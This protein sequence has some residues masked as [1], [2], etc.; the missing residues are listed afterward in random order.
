MIA[1]KSKIRQNALTSADPHYV[2]VG[3]KYKEEPKIL[4]TTEDPP[5]TPPFPVPD[6]TL[7]VN[8]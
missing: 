3:F 8:H 1:R 5:F 6:G 2:A 7:L 4:N